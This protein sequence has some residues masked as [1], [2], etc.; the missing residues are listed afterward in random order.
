MSKII[1]LA[2]QKG[3]VGKTTTAVNLA[4]SLAHLGEETLLVDMD[5]QA[6]ATS[7]VGIDK[8]LEAN[9][10]R[11]LLSEIP[12]DDAVRPTEID[13]LDVVPSTLDLIAAEI[14]LAG[15]EERE[16]FL[17]KVLA[18]FHKVYK[19]IIIDCPPSLG[20]LTLNSLAAAD[21]IIIPLQCEYYAL[22]G[23]GQLLKTIELIREGLNP[24]LEIEGV[25][26][27]MYDSRLNLANQ[28][29]AEVK[30][31]FKEKTYST[32]IPRTVRL[33][34]APSFGKPIITYDKN[35]KGAEVYLELAEEFLKK[36]K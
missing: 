12:L 36:Q 15:A 20:L 17:K 29:I 14:E 16:F 21:S 7:G 25:L 31:H 24:K 32:V 26:I 35:S 5:P 34:E 30:K 28:V 11:A 27:T 22:E 4:A 13:W 10:Y 2:N 6:N 19:Y 18:R 3:G 8:N 9:I 33:A 1:A 23:L